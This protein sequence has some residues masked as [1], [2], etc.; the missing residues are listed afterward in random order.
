LIPVSAKSEKALKELAGKYAFALTA[1]EFS[2][3]DFASSTCFHRT[4]H[5][6]RLAVVAQSENDLREKLLG[7]SMGDMEKGISIGQAVTMEQADPVF[8]YTGMGPQWWAMG[9]ELREKE[10]VFREALAECDALFRK[11][12]NWPL[13]E[14]L[15]ADEQ[16]SRMAETEVAQR[17]NFA[18]QVALT[19]LW[20]SWGI[21]PGAVVGHSVGEVSAAY[22]SGALSFEDAVRVSYHRSRLQ[23]SR[24]GLGTMLAVGLPEADAV[25]LIKRYDRVSIGA[26][27]SPSAFTLSGDEEELRG[28]AKTLEKKIVFNRFLRV[29]VAYHSYQMD[30]LQEELLE[31]LKGIEGQETEVPLYSTIFGELTLGAEW[32]TPYWWK[33]VRQPVR[34]ARAINSL[35]SDGYRHFVEV[36]PHPVLG[37]SIKECAIQAEVK[38]YVIPSLYRKSPELFRM[39]ESLGQ[40]Y[41]LGYRVEWKNIVPKIGRYVSLP[42]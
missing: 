37:T 5:N 19:V 22:T 41:T 23:Q 27:N 32:G 20:E 15:D 1:D 14:A 28:I 33:N 34:F 6:H 42:T 3:A 29:E 13:M 30:P 21:K 12:F 10:P 8:V 9:R 11:I 31:C 36:G 18:I 4:H 25:E 2:L 17:C 35:L 26:I 40:L 16:S 7:F 24:A 39:L 38:A